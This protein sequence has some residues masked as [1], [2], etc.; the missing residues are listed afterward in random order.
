MVTH[1]QGTKDRGQGSNLRPPV[2][3]G[4]TLEANDHVPELN[5][6]VLPLHHHS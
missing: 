6:G 1:K 4:T 5:A 3:I 2:L